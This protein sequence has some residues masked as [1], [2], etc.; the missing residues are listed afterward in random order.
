[1][2]LFEKDR[3][4]LEAFRAGRRD[5]LETVFEAYVEDVARLVRLGFSIDGRAHIYGIPDPDEQREIIH[6]VFVRAF[7]E[8]ARLRYDGL[9][10]YRPYLLRIAQNLMIDRARRVQRRPANV[11]S[12][13][14]PLA[15]EDLVS[16][17]ATTPSVEEDLDWNRQRE[18]AARYMDALP[19]TEREFVR[20][21]FVEALPQTKVAEALGI[22]RRRVRTLEKRALRGLLQL[23]KREKLL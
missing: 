15:F 16:G 23:L 4:L 10:P 8:R 21:R 11:G 13:M 9:R 6:D 3:H 2:T 7:D 17:R 14:E 5:A 1:M 20:L 12:G 19:E 22:T 18:A